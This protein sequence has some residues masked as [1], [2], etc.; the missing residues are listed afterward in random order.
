MPSWK[1]RPS[2]RV[3]FHVLPSSS[4][5]CGEHLRLGVA[6]GVEREQ[7][8][9]EHHHAVV[10]GDEGAGVGV[11]QGEVGAGNEFQRGGGERRAKSAGREMLAVPITAVVRARNWR[12]FMESLLGPSGGLALQTLR[13]F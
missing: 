11:Q 1:V 3:S 13:A 6:G 7:R 2:R 4:V 9:V 5:M 12:L 10:A 8:E